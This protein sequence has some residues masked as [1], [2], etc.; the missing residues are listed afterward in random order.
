[1]RPQ[2]IEKFDQYMGFIYKTVYHEPDTPN[3]HHVLIDKIVQDIVL[4]LDLAKDS[5]VYDIGCGSGYFMEKMR[6]AGYANLIGLTM[7]DADIA[8]CNAKQLTVLKQDFTF[9]D[10]ESSS[11]DLIFCRQAI[12]HSPFPV[13][14]LMEFNRI[15]KLGSKVYI[16]VPAPDMDRKHEEN[17]N[18]F[19]IMGLKMWKALF[20]RTGFHIDYAEPYDFSV[21]D[22][23][24]SGI[25]VNQ[26]E[27]FYV[28][29]LTKKVDILNQDSKII[30]INNL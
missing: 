21:T 2:D 9:S 27:R 7:D 11:V 20:D 10:I 13:L 22:E 6:D 23:I 5:T 16:E 26:N 18:H 17:F 25:F 12:E 14:T 4:P 19:S 28:C 3:F 8:N 1:M 15:A 30:N 24:A 29:L